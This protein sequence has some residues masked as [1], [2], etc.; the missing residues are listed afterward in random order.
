MAACG[1]ISVAAVD[2]VGEEEEVVVVVERE[3]EELVVFA[4]EFPSIKGEE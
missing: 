2:K 3:E 4:T 1:V